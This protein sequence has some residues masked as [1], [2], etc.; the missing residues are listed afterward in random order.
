V[1]QLDEVDGTKREARV[2]QLHEVDDGTQRAG[3]A[4][5]EPVTRRWLQH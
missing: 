3:L 2:E 5:L 1:D 4:E